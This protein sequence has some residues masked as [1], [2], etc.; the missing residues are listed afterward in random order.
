MIDDASI[1]ALLT[2]LEAAIERYGVTKFSPASPTNI[3]T[4]ESNYGVV[5]PPLVRAYF[6]RFGEDDD[7][8]DPNLS[9]FWP[10]SEV[11]LA[12]TNWGLSLNIET[13]QDELFVFGDYCLDCWG[14]AMQLN[15]NATQAA[16]V[17]TT[18]GS[19]RE[20]NV[21]VADSFEGFLRMYIE[22]FDG[23]L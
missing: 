21:Q 3:S 17:Y 7:Q 1:E 4:F 14:Y 20:P 23:I 9:R 19:S 8:I 10:L 5:L 12:A 15:R 2:D 18:A 11:E 6:M 22:D 13:L 16:P